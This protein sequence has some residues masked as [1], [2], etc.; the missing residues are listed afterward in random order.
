MK[1]KKKKVSSRSSL[2]CNFYFNYF[3]FNLVS[4]DTCLS[5]AKVN[6]C[7]IVKISAKA[8]INVCEYV[9]VLAARKK[10]AK[11]NLV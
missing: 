7:R 8:K 6:P 3:S 10:V 9:K 2:T 1:K 4:R 5:S 11:L